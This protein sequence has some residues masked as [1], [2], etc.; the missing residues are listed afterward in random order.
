LVNGEKQINNK[1]FVCTSAYN[2]TDIEITLETAYLNASKPEN[3]YFGIAMQYPDIQKPDLSLYKNVR[4]IDIL[5]AYPIGTSPSRAI[6]AKLIEDEDYF[7]SIDAHTIFKKDWDKNLIE[8]FSEI[9][10]KYKKP[11]ISTYSPYWYRD[12]Q[13]CIFNQNKNVS[14]EEEMAQHTLKFKMD[15][16]FFPENYTMP[17]PTWDKVVT[18]RYQE[19]YLIGAHLLFAESSYLNEVPFDPYITYHEENTT[20]MRAWTRGYRIFAIDKDIL[21]TREMYHGVADADSWRKKIERK[22]SD[23]FTYAD[24]ISIGALRCKDI[25]LGKE[26]GLYGSPSIDLL[27]EYEVTAGVDHESVYKKIYDRVEA[28]PDAN[29]PARSMYNFDKARNA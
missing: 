29:T 3:I 7:L 17:T 6:A 20:A 25:L 23:G 12:E 28:S 24:K 14:F 4:T 2:D 19:H 18:S 15:D 10:E 8:Y 11:I 22:S 27:K 5:D 16:E 13:G 26:L 9:K 21:W 1:I